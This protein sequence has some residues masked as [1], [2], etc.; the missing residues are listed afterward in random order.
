MATVDVHVLAT[1]PGRLPSAAD[2]EVR[3]AVCGL[4][5]ED[6]LERLRRA[7]VALDTLSAPVLVD[8]E[9]ARTD[10]HLLVGLLAEFRA[11]RHLAGRACRVHGLNPA[12]TPSLESMALPVLVAVHAEMLRE[13]EE[14]CLVPAP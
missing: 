11:R 7:C 13:S 2:V 5:D 3:V 14:Q 4:V 12:N 9:R 1:T 8:V 10:G 6:G